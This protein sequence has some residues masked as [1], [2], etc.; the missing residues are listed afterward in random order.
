[1]GKVQTFE[2][3]IVWQK[4]RALC[5]T[6]FS[7]SREN[8]FSKDW[9]FKG[10]ILSSSGSIMDNIAEGFGRSSSKEFVQYLLIAHGSAM[11]TKSQLYRALDFKYIDERAFAELQAQISEIGK[12]IFSLFQYLKS[13][14]I[15]GQ[16]HKQ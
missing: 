12:M 7:L 8:E 10:Q 16:K 9:R 11:E 5:K 13:T 6:I 15:K 2:D 4:A 3:L 1:M 14:P